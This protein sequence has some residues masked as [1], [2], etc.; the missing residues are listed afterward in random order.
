MMSRT[1]AIGGC[2]STCGF[3]TREPA[4]VQRRGTQ[5]VSGRPAD[6]CATGH[7]PCGD[8]GQPV[9]V[10][11]L[12]I[13]R[14]HPQAANQQYLAR[15]NA[16]PLPVPGKLAANHADLVYQH[17]LAL[18]ACLGNAAPAAVQ[19][20]SAASPSSAMD[21]SRRKR[22]NIGLR[23]KAD[24]ADSPQAAC[25]GKPLSSQAARAPARTG[26]A[27]AGEATAVQH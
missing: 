26:V 25:A 15:L 9:R 3:A 10:R 5:P 12:R 19:V 22:W 11:A 17:L 27:A 23:R 4:G 1:I 2:S 18:K 16:D 20:G 7:R 24:G 8:R 21:N 14:L 6:L 13:A